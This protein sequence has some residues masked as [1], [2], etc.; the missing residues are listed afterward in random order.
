MSQ[1]EASGSEF[2][3]GWKV[4]IA[5]VARV[6]CGASPIPFNMIGFTTD[7]IMAESGWSRTEI[8]L[9]ITIFGVVAALLAPFFGSLAG[10][11]FGM[12]NYSKIYGFLYVPFGLFSAGSPL[13]Y[14]YLRDTTGSYDPILS[15]GIAAFILG[16]GVLVLMGKYPASFPANTANLNPEEATA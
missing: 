15:F 16:G 13:I 9:P 11:Y 8:L 7:P 1:V 3:T 2:S 12:A 14:A 6:A 10:R 5:A 4:L